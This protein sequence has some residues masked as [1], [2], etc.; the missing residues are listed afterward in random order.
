[1]A[2]PRDEAEERATEEDAARFRKK[3]FIREDMWNA[4]G[5]RKADR[6]NLGPIYE[7]FA[8]ASEAQLRDVLRKTAD[9][10]QWIIKRH[11]P[12]GMDLPPIL[13][14]NRPDDLVRTGGP[15]KH[16]HGGLQAPP[17]WEC[18]DH[19]EHWCPNC[20]ST[21]N[22][23][24]SE[25][26]REHIR[27][28]GS[29][30]NARKRRD[31]TCGRDCP[32]RLRDKRGRRYVF[33]K[34]EPHHGR[35]ID[36]PHFHLDEGKYQHA[37][38]NWVEK[39]REHNHSWYVARKKRR[40]LEYHI[41]RD[42]ADGP[43]PDGFH[44]HSYREKDR[45]NGTASRIS[46]NPLMAR[47]LSA[48]KV[49]FFGI[50]GC[51]KECAMGS[52][53]LDHDLDASVFSVPAVHNWDAPELADFA[54]LYLRGKTVYIVADADAY[55]NK[56]GVMRPARL[57]RLFLQSLNLGIDVHIALPP[58][59]T[60]RKWKGVD[61]YLAA[62]GR[63]EDL[64]I[65][66]RDPEPKLE[67]VIRALGHRPDREE[68]MIAVLRALS[69]VAG[70][71]GANQATERSQARAARMNHETFRRGRQYLAQD[72]LVDIKGDPS[73]RQKWYVS[74]LYELRSADYYA[75][76]DISGKNPEVV[77]RE[78]LRAVDLP[79]RKLGLIPKCDIGGNY[80]LAKQLKR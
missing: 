38:N 5:F 72:K 76:K 22:F 37:R 64:E 23:F 9:Q 79:K 16:Q 18:P 8:D 66:D 51:I 25:E 48:A 32:C 44:P 27:R 71:G 15:T 73:I 33:H 19:K 42:H 34:D 36:W 30:R 14:E 24:S 52:Y 29:K 31:R 69:M 55:Q 60:R 77:I 75:E 28:G 65:N 45:E 63:L 6:N 43:P 10:P 17:P 3:H 13:P 49:V 67:G 1:M 68:T 50:E 26:R 40:A 35:N 7:E 2:L 47:R 41:K 56:I 61:D 58:A 57:C 74:K 21:K 39:I 20:V 78:D 11:L 59:R 80:L 4:Q 46:I 53:V 62:E 54:R 12:P 70:P